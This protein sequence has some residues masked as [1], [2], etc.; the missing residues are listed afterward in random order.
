M[1]VVSWQRDRLGFLAAFQP[2]EAR[3]ISCPIQV[4]DGEVRAYVNASGLGEH[5]WLQISLLDEG[6]QPLPGYS[7]ADAAIVREDGLRLPVRWPG[8]N[9]L[10]AAHGRV[11]LQVHF[12]GVRPEDCRLYAVYLG[13][14]E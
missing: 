2:Q 1:R 7:G 8:G 5:S 10:L 12:D 4:V 9:S 14:D 6:C 3:A 13:D 11:R